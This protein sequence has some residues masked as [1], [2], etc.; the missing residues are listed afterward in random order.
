MGREGREEDMKGKRKDFLE[1]GINDDS[2]NN[3]KKK[4]KKGRRK[5]ISEEE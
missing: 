3:N 2:S 5:G 4:D 1:E